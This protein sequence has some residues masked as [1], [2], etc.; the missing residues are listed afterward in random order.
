MSRLKR[1]SL[2]GLRWLQCGW[3]QL[4]RNPWLLGGMGIAC[5]VVVSVL[6]LVPLIGRPIVA[7]LAP[8]FL[9]SAFLALDAMTR[10][11]LPLP[12]ALRLPA[13]KQ[14]PIAL[15]DVFRDERR[16]IPIFLVGLYSLAAALVIDL[17]ALLVTGRAWTRPWSALDGTSLAAVL[18]TVP[19]VLALYFLLAA[20]LVY[21][22]PL[23]FLK[24]EALAP[25]LQRSVKAALHYVYALLI[26]FAPLLVAP[27]VGA[28]VG[29]S[30]PWTAHALQLLLNALALP[31]VACGLYCSYRTV[32]PSPEAAPRASAPGTPAHVR[33][34]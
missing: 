20:S 34:P 6:A 9:A 29:R 27:V 18:A 21:T 30:A 19:L 17:C 33:C 22:L 31:L 3:R 7:L 13:L 12:A 2:L 32:F 26:V 28:M 23:T 16:A 5:S 15:L 24:D 1:H 14:S 11:K 10:Q 4:R 8:M 25:A